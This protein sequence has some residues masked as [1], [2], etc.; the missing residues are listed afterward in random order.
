MIAREGAGR[1]GRKAAHALWW[2]A[3]ALTSNS[4]GKILTVF[5]RAEGQNKNCNACAGLWTFH[6][7]S[8][9]TTVLPAAPAPVLTPLHSLTYHLTFLLCLR[10]PKPESHGILQSPA[11]LKAR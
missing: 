7:E 6:R 8:H 11:S 10:N 5:Q 1:G 9:V 2:N 4:R 3:P